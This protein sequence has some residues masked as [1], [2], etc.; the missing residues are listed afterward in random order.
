MRILVTHVT[1]MAEGFCCVAGIEEGGHSH[2]RPVLGERLPTS[3]LA[4][5]GGP[6]DMGAVVELGRAAPI[7]R[8]PEFEDHLFWVEQSSRLG[9]VS[10]ARLWALVLG[11]ARTELDVIFGSQLE[12]DGSRASVPQGHG[13]ASL[14]VYRPNGPVRLTGRMR[15][16]RDNLRVLLPDEGLDLSLTDARFFAPGFLRPSDLR[17]AEA[18]AALEAG[19]QVVLGV[20][21]TRPYAPDPGLPP[22]HWLQV[23]ALHMEPLVGW[24]LIRD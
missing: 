3:L 8:R 2:I 1:R 24:R 5:L 10:P 4:T 11:G 21:L 9:Y 17:V 6:F 23:N 14:G 19:S 12:K 13:D 18:R 16:G 7:G 20:G 22:R 15:D